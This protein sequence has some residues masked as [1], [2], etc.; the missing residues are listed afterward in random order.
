MP[1]APTFP[2][3]AGLASLRRALA[4]RVV[5]LLALLSFGLS[6]AEAL[7]A[8]SRPATL[9]PDAPGVSALAGPAVAAVR[10]ESPAGDEADCPPGCL[11]SCPCACVLARILPPAETV[12]APPCLESSLPSSTP[13]RRPVS[14]P[15]SPRVRP[16]LA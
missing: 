15:R 14:V 11:C 8:E 12:P 13:E 7:F 10:P 4:R 6:S 9:S 2:R 5:T 1:R 16:P 3:D